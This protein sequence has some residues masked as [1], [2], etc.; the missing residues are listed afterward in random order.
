VEPLGDSALL[1]HYRN[2]ETRW[3]DGCIDAC[4]LEHLQ[5]RWSFQDGSELPTHNPGLALVI[6][7]V[8][9]SSQAE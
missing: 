4:G 5:L 7:V 8:S 2:D 1:G 3:R 9:C 6:S